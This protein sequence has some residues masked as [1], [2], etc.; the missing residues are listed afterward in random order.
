MIR[1]AATLVALVAV[2][3][4]QP[5]AA[6]TPYI[7]DDGAHVTIHAPIREKTYYPAGSW[8]GQAQP[9]WEFCF[10]HDGGWTCLPVSVDDYGRYA[11]GQ[12]V[13]ARHR[14]GELAEISVG[15]V[16]R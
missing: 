2:A 5:T 4:C 13:I 6:P 11:E 10:D 3:G 9:R 7:T 15:E 14:V 8:S 1:P 16:A 12:V